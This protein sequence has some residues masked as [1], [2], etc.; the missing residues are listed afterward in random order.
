MLTF[1]KFKN[2]QKAPKV[3]RKKAGRYTSTTGAGAVP[4][5]RRGAASL[6]RTSALLGCIVTLPNGS[7]LRLLGP[8]AQASALAIARAFLPYVAATPVLPAGWSWTAWTAGGAQS[9]SAG[10]RGVVLTA[11]G[12]ARRQK[13]PTF[14]LPK[15]RKF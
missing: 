11:G 10:R 14:N 1:R 2:E 7:R 13:P 8:G 4:P 12:E 5:R 3:A 9:W 15:K 6:P